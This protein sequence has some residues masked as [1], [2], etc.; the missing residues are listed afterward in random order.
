MN[1]SADPLRWV[2]RAGIGAVLVIGWL[3]IVWQNRFHL[4]APVVIV[5][6]AF[7]AVVVTVVTLWRTGASAA[8]PEHGGD[9]WTRPLGA[10]DALE[11]EKR[12]LLK[13]IKEA[14]FDREM[15]KLSPRDADDM[16][17][18]YRARAIEVIKALEGYDQNQ[19]SVR[20]RIER[21]VKARLE[22]EREKGPKK[23]KR[24]AAGEAAS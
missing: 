14:E 8:A 23:K 21:E 24:K 18:T 12:T 3:F 11:K 22:L 19:A 1:A 20:E 10:G 9:E 17:R 4:T 15:G 2:R 5:C 16:I 7:L 6:L 13:A